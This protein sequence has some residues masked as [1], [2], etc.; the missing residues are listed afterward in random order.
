MQEEIRK[1][2]SHY[3]ILFLILALGFWG[4]W[5]FSYSLAIRQTIVLAV[6]ILYLGWGII[7]HLLEGN[8]NFK[9]V[10]EYTL[11]AALAAAVLL[12]ILAGG[13]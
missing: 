3:L 5:Y 7:H 4:F 6:A 13:L 9:I 11:F 2:L 12:I 10:V 8:L 1:H